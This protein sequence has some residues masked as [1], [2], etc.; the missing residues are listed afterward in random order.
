[1]PVSERRMP[2]QLEMLELMSQKGKKIFA[3]MTTSVAIWVIQYFVESIE[4]CHD[5]TFQ[6][7]AMVTTSVTI[8]GIAAETAAAR[9]DE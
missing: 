6:D 2:N 3:L 5:D 7:F 4:K 1:M 9:F 8:R